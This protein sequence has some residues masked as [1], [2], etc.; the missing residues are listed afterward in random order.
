M[1]IHIIFLNKRSKSKHRDTLS[2]NLI[3]VYSY[4]LFALFVECEYS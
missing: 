1:A 3:M 4:Y 2:K